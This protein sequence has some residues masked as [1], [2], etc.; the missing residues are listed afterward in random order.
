MS[1]LC[2]PFPR[3]VW[4]AGVLV[5]FGPRKGEQTSSPPS[6]VRALSGQASTYICC[7]MLEQTPDLCSLSLREG[8]LWLLFKGLESQGHLVCVPVHGTVVLQVC[9]VW[10]CGC[11]HLDSSWETCAKGRMQ[12]APT[13]WR[14]LVFSQG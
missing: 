14:K 12:F 1:G 3:S 11:P 5:E 8:R 7:Q 6:Q 9:L 10:G 2:F 13:S 4:N